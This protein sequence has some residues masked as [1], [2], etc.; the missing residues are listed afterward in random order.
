MVA[1]GYDWAFYSETQIM[2]IA[3][4]VDVRGNGEGR[5]ISPHDIL[6]G[7]SKSLPPLHL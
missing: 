6:I 2:W 1:L 7:L 5:Y 4:R 3:K